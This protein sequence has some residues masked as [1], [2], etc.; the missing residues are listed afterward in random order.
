VGL[1]LK[2]YFI[3]KLKEPDL[4]VEDRESYQKL[5]LLEMVRSLIKYGM[6][7]I[8]YN[9][10][11]LTIIAK[12]KESFEAFTNSNLKP[13]SYAAKLEMY[14]K[15]K[16]E[17]LKPAPKLPKKGKEDWYQF[18]KLKSDP[19]IVFTEL[20]FQ[21]LHKALNLVIFVDY[22]K[23]E[24]LLKYLKQI[25]TISNTLNLPIP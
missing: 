10:S 16:S 11:T 18:Y 7:I 15:S 2:D 3:Q 22:P 9:A 24:S 8:P 21:N 23:L 12:F 1:K 14:K 19:S 20:D 4:S 5:S 13:N 17:N 25:A 6:M